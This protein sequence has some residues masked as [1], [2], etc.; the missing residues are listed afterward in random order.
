MNK[1]TWSMPG[2]NDVGEEEEQEE[3]PLVDE[4]DQ[5]YLAGMVPTLEDMV[6][7]IRSMNILSKEAFLSYYNLIEPPF[8]VTGTDQRFVYLSESY[9]RILSSCIATVVDSMG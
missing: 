5:A 6:A 1:E 7:D 8:S 3:M 4:D 2:F 9:R